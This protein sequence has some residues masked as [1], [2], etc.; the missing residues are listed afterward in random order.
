MKSWR[1][2]FPRK[3]PVQ[4]KLEQANSWFSIK[5]VLLKEQKITD[6]FLFCLSQIS[7]EELI[8]LKLEVS[9]RFVNKR[10]TRFFGLPIWKSLNY[11][12]KDAALK[13]AVSICPTD[14]TEKKNSD[15]VYPATPFRILGMTRREFDYYLSLFGVD[16]YVEYFFQKHYIQHLTESEKSL[17]YS[18]KKNKQIIKDLPKN[19]D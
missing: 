1:D 10:T 19:N 2:L 4:H 3:E 15:K 18:Y 16:R 8:A 9:S 5:E 17:F 6:D 7:L 12:S 11:I 13:W 14:T